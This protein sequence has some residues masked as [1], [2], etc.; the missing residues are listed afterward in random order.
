MTVLKVRPPVVRIKRH[1]DY[2]VKELTYVP[3][4]MQVVSPEIEEKLND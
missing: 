3:F 2:D 4:E 1:R